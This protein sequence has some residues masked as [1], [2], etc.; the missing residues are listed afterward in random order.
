M[1]TSI[2]MELDAYFKVKTMISEVIRRC[3]WRLSETVCMI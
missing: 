2:T 1:E 3:L